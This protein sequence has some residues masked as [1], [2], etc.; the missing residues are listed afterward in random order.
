MQ[1]PPPLHLSYFLLSPRSLYQ[2]TVYTAAT[3][4]VNFPLGESLVTLLSEP[5]APFQSAC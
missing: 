5:A 1:E 4:N 3:R 2:P